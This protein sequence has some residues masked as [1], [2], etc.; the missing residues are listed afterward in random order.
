MFNFSKFTFDQNFILKLI[1]THPKPKAFLL[2]WKSKDIFM[3]IIKK[4]PIEIKYSVPEY[5][6]DEE[7]MLELIT[8]SLDL[9]LRRFHHLYR[10]IQTLLTQQ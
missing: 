6:N 4:N 8:Q 2:K 3:K 10:K 1:Q 9:T 5:N 7:I